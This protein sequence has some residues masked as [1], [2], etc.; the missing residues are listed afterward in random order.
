MAQNKRKD[1]ILDSL[2]KLSYKEIYSSQLKF[3]NKPSIAIIYSQAYLEKGKEENDTIRIANAY[4]QFILLLDFD[5][6]VRYADSII[7][8]TGKIKHKLYPGDGYLLKGTLLYYLG[9]YSASLENL[10][11][12]QKYADINNNEKQL[13]TVKEAIGQLKSISGNFL[14]SL[15]ISK[16][17]LDIIQKRND[18]DDYKEDY[19]RTLN[20]LSLNYLSLNE[21]DSALT[22][23]NK[24]ILKS[25]EFKDTLSYYDFVANSGVGMYLKKEY[26]KANDSLDK[27]FPFDE[28]QNSRINYYL[29]KGRIARNTGDIE[30]AIVNFE[31]LD[32]IYELHQDPVRE[33]PEV[34]WTF[35]NY[36]REKGDTQSQLKYID[37]LLTADSVI[38]ANFNY[39]NTN[40]AKEYDIPQ[41]TAEKD[42]LIRSLQT[43]KAQSNNGIVILSLLFLL[44]GGLFFYYYR[45]QRIYKRK[46]GYLMQEGKIAD[47]KA[48]SANQRIN[49]IS[50]E[51]IRRIVDGLKAFEQKNEFLDPSITLNS[52]SKKLHT[53]SNYLSKV[54]NHYEQKNFS[55]YINDLRIDYTVEQLKTNKQFR[56]YSVKGIAEEVGFNST[57]SFSKAFFKRT[58]IYPSY[59]I[60]QL[61]K[62][63][64]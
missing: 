22:I 18:T 58:G 53:N 54:I 17:I 10:L 47:A 21:P 3:E 23:I 33:L 2:K 61:R 59:F 25:L 8:L 26:D 44:F 35:V 31:R 7:N 9:N 43:K 41:L 42:E 14:E 49:G 63:Q 55:N 32:S 29:Y 28:D 19:L 40:I 56:L 62:Q 57:E 13:L 16:E 12:A 11:I 30:N 39:L 46:F 20:N 64:A 48:K 38:D 60:R 45:K 52:L 5:I 6:G 15:A 27:A 37:K 4:T 51:L 1:K 24:G 36:Y 50:E 34:Y